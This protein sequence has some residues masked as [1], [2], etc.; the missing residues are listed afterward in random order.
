MTRTIHNL[1]WELWRERLIEYRFMTIP[2]QVSLG[3][4]WDLQSAISALV[5]LDCVQASKT[6]EN[7]GIWP[8]HL[9]RDHAQEQ[10]LLP[11]EGREPL[12]QARTQ[13]VPE[14]SPFL[15]GEARGTWR[16]RLPDMRG[17]LPRIE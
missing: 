9:N 15:R 6:L 17:D 7:R 12:G 16:S 3:M 13:G 2:G 4:Q 11:M 14:S 8:L 1:R 10:A 5:S